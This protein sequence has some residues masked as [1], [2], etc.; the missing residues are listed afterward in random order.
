VAAAESID[1]LGPDPPPTYARAYRFGY[2]QIDTRRQ[3]PGRPGS[4]QVTRRPE[5]CVVLIR[6]RVPAYITWDRFQ[7]NQDRLAANRNI[8]ESA[9]A[10]RNGAALLGGL[11]SCGRFTIAIVRRLAA[12]HGLPRREPYGSLAELGP[13]EFRPIGLAR[14]LGVT[15]YQVRQWHRH[16]WLN[17]RADADGHYIIWADADELRR[18]R[19][20]QRL[21]RMG[22]T[23]ARLARLKKPKLRGGK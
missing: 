1:A 21:Q 14:R 16:G 15:K 4:G 6:D 22:V 11:F 7:A 23:G 3:T 19:Q 9:G 2:R 18:L 13:D 10:P 12:V 5:E 17:V 8:P 20:L